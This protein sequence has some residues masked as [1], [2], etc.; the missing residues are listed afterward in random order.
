MKSVAKR[1]A[2]PPKLESK[3]AELARNIER[4]LAA[5]GYLPLRAVEVRVHEGLVTL[6]GQVPTYYF[7]QLAQTAA[8]QNQC[9]E[10]LQNDIEVVSTESSRA[11]FRDT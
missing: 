5:S 10:M 6:K 11:R 2:T 8:M 7:K 1:A 9:V 3:D 4:A